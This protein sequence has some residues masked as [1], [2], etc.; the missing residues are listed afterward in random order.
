LVKAI[1]CQQSVI[2]AVNFRVAEP[3]AQKHHW[4]PRTRFPGTRV[5]DP[6][7]SVMAPIPWLAPLM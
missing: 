2:L 3:L 6:E 5:R 4:F 7:Y 1:F